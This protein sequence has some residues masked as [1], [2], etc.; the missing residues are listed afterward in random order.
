MIAV[1][2]A[3]AQRLQ[4]TKNKKDKIDIIYNGIN[5]GEYD[6]PQ[7]D[8]K[9]VEELGKEEE[10]VLVGTASQLISRKGHRILLNAAARILHTDSKVKF[11]IVGSGKKS[12][13]K[14]LYDLTKELG[15]ENN[16]IFL[17]WRENTSQILALLDIVVL[18][19]TQPEG[20]SRLILEAMASSKPV[21]ASKIGGNTEAVKEGTTG[22]IVNPGDI[23]SLATALLQLV[24]NKTLRQSMGKAGKLRVKEQFSIEQNVRQIQNL[25]E[26]LLCRNM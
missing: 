4:K 6:Q 13:T 14:E 26:E 25:Y 12:Y 10:F 23:D 7:T 19:S 8:P 16:V 1:S 11:V 2:E 20:F 17:G 24:Q 21:V 18:P 3:V 5:L 9:L 15:I 22:L